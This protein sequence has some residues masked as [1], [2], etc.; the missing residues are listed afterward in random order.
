MNNTAVILI[1]IL[2]IYLY[3]YYMNVED[4]NV[5]IYDDEILSHY[6]SYPYSAYGGHSTSRKKIS[7]NTMEK[8]N[9]INGRSGSNLR[10]KMLK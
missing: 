6:L 7:K 8:Y 9:R 4:T 3:Y 2:F 5:I 10:G 1:G